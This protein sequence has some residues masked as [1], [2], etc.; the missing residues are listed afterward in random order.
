MWPASISRGA[1]LALSA[2]MEFPCT[3]A[4]TSSAKVMTSSAPAGPGRVF[5]GGEIATGALLAEP[6]QRHQHHLGRERAQLGPGAGRRARTGGVAHVA[7][8]G[9][10]DQL[11]DPVAGDVGG[12]QPLEDEDTRGRW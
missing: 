12:I 7:P 1:P 8:A 4:F 10:L 11:G 3:S 5:D 2:A 6:A 9:K